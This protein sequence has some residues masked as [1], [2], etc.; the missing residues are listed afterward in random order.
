MNPEFIIKDSKLH[1]FLIHWNPG[2][3]KF[4]TLLYYS[5]KI[6]IKMVKRVL[7]EKADP[8]SESEIIFQVQILKALTRM[9][10]WC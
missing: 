8:V 4:T 3:N 7:K 6:I 5:I 10:Q 9:T 1:A 2:E